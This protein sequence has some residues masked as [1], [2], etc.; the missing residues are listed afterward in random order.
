MH[1]VHHA[2]QVVRICEENNTANTAV[3]KYRTSARKR[4]TLSHRDLHSNLVKACLERGD[5]SGGCVHLCARVLL[6]S[7]ILL[8]VGLPAVCR[9]TCMYK[10]MRAC[11]RKENLTAQKKEA[12]TTLSPVVSRYSERC[13]ARL[14]TTSA[15]LYAYVVFTSGQGLYFGTCSRPKYCCER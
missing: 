9:Q 14:H 12:A 15:A 5:S 13:S 1:A 3:S 7:T 11:N 4:R 8:V 6:I 10:S 2:L